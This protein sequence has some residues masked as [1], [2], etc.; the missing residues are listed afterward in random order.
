MILF[1]VEEAKQKIPQLTF[2]FL[3][4]LWWK[5]ILVLIGSYLNMN[6]QN[7][8]GSFIILLKLENWKNKEFSQ[9]F[10]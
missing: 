5:I 2:F 6:Q 7:T 1:L 9:A 8:L 4:K 3:T 10:R